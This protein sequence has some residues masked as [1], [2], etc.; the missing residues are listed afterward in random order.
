LVKSLLFMVATFRWTVVHSLLV[1]VNHGREHNPA[2]PSTTR[3]DLRFG[4]Y[5][6]PL[7]MIGETIIDEVRGEVKIVGTSPGR[8]PWPVGYAAGGRSLVVF[9]GLATAIR[10]EANQAVC[11]HWG[12]TGQ[13]VS[14]WRKALGIVGQPAPGTTALRSAYLH[15]SQGRKMRKALLPVLSSSE[16][17]A[18]IS[19]AKKGVPR[20]AETIEKMRQAS[21]GK[22]ASAATRAK[23]SSA[24]KRRRG[25]L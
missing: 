25:T 16:R 12:I 23:M 13:T 20:S 6:T 9:A 1:A 4:P 21:L 5:P 8:I 22:R 24:H 15:G 17:A 18:K 7:Y 10:Q 14:K 2:M 19:A 3:F 11:H